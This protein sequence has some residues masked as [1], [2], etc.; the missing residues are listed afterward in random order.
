MPTRWGHQRANGS[1]S[2]RSHPRASQVVLED[3]S[4]QGPQVLLYKVKD[5]FKTQS[6]TVTA[7][8]PEHLRHPRC[9]N[10]QSEAQSRQ[11]QGALPHGHR[12]PLPSTSRLLS[13]G[14]SWRPQHFLPPAPRPRAEPAS[15]S[16]LLAIPPPS[17]NFLLLKNRTT[18][19]RLVHTHREQLLR[20]V[21]HLQ[22]FKMN[23]NHL[24]R[25]I[26]GR[27]LVIFFSLKIKKQPFLKLAS[28]YYGNGNAAY[29]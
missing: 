17:C 7:R 24:C 28:I 25:Q 27:F 1:E 22:N 26:E 5:A 16:G 8:A 11:G 10:G 15:P 12:R 18:P 19:T 14:L 2:L 29:T 3:A 13:R 23:P 21:E 9:D 4:S 6:F 20:W